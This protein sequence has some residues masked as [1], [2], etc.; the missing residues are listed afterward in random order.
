M[1]GN[2]LFVFEMTAKHAVG[3]GIFVC[4]CL[5]L[6][7]SSTVK[8]GAT[9]TVTDGRSLGAALKREDVKVINIRGS[10][11]QS[12]SCAAHGTALLH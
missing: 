8:Q 12:C 11:L 7:V 1:P 6:G 4:C 3:L 9:V 2:L 5:V 10:P